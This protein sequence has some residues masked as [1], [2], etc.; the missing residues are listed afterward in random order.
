MYSDALVKYLSS[1][2]SPNEISDPGSASVSA[3]ASESAAAADDDDDDDDEEFR[4]ESISLHSTDMG[5]VDDLVYDDQG[6]QT[7]PVV[8]DAV[9]EYSEVLTEHV[10][11]LPT[12]ATV[13]V[14]FD[15]VFYAC[16]LMRKQINE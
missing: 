14:I 5:A 3:P 2:A 7:E 16:S 10:A 13:K 15:T 11:A 6:L 1:A 12:H 9:A 4:P 8:A